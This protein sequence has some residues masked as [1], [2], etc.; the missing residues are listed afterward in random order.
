M[1]NKIHDI[2]REIDTIF[3]FDF[4]KIQTFEN[5][6]KIPV[7]TILDIDGTSNEKIYQD[8]GM[9]KYYC[10]M[11]PNTKY[12][13]HL[14]NCTEVAEILQGSVKDLVSNK[15]YANRDIIKYD[16]GVSHEILNTYDGITYLLVTFYKK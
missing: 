10:K 8:N 5:N 3:N 13:I 16:K 4:A 12:K 6:L 11:P 7:G 9:I 2:I 1:G 14:H 15:H